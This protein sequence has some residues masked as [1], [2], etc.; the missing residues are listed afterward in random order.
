MNLNILYYITSGLQHFRI[1]DKPFCINYPLKNKEKNYN[2]NLIK[3][4]LE[5]D[6]IDISIIDEYRYLDKN[7]N[8]FIKIKES[9]LY[10]IKSNELILQIHLGKQIN[11]DLLEIETS[12]SNMKTII[13]ELEYKININ[14]HYKNDN[15]DLYYLYASP[16]V[17]IKREDEYEEEYK[18]I[19]Y[20]PE[21]KYIYNIFENSKKEC[22]CIFECANEKKLREALI[23]QPKILHISSHGRLDENLKY[24]L[25]LEEKGV[26]QKINLDRIKEILTTFRNQIKKIDLVFASTCYSEALGKLFLEYGI[27]NVIYIQGMTPV[28]DKA[29]IKFSEIFYSELIRGNTIKNAFNKSKKLIQSDKEKETFQYRKCCCSHWHKSIMY[30]PLKKDLDIHNKYHIK[31]DCDCEEYNIHEEYCKLLKM[32]KNDKAEKYFYF[33]KNSNNTIKICCICCKPID[34]N[35]KMLPH[36]ESFKFILKQ[37][38]PKDDYA[39]FYYKNKGKMNKNKNCYIMNNKDIF[40]K[41]AIVGRRKQVK[42]I[43]DI[44]DNGNIH[45]II[46]HGSYEVG[47]QNFAEQ[48]C[49][50]L[51]ERKIINGYWKINVKESKEEVSDKIKELTNNGKNSDGK[52]IVIIKINYYLEKPISLLNEILNEKSIMNPYFYYIIL[53]V[54]QDDEIGHLIH[55]QDKY[56]ILY[57]MNLI[58]ASAKQLLYDLCDSYGY[59]IHFKNL[60]I[61]NQIEELLELTGY[62]RININEL[63]ELIGKYNNFEKLKNIIQSQEFNNSG[64]IQNE[65]RKLMENQISKIYYLLTIMVNG[66]PAS[67]IYLYE[68]DFKKIIRKEDEEK[69]IYI[70]PNNNWYTIIE[71]RYKKYMVQYIQEGLKK[72]YICKC[73]EIYAKLLFFY[74]EKTRKKVCF[75]DC[76]IHYNFNSY[77]NKGIW[78][79]F[80]NNIY[81]LYFLK[82]DKSNTYNNIL[83][84]DFILEKHADNIYYL[85]ANNI[86]IIKDLIYIDRDNNV[87]QKEYLYQILLMLPSIYAFKKYSNFKIIMSKCLHL[88]DK[89]KES[90]KYNLLDSKQRLNLFFLSMKE[91]STIDF[92]KISLLGDEG[93]A[94]AYFINGIKKKDVESFLNSINLYQKIN[95]K[96]LNIQIPYAY[97]EIG[98]IYFLEKNYEYAKYYLNEGEELSKVYNDGFIKDKINIELALVMEAKYHNKDKYEFYL[99]KV[100]NESA[101]VYLISEANNLLNKLNAKLEPDIIM[102]NSNPFTKKNNYSILRYSMWAY[103]NNQYNLLQKFAKKIKRNIRIKSIVLNEKN[104]IEAFKEKGKFLIIQSD[105]FNEE[106]EIHLETKYGEGE[107]L[108]N[109]KLQEII[110]DQLN[111]E[112]VILCFIKSEKIKKYFEGKVKYLITFN[113]INIEDIDPDLLLPYNQLSI[114][115]LIHFLINSIN[116]NINQSFENSLKTFKI[117]LENFKN[118]TIDLIDKKSDFITLNIYDI[119]NKHINQKKYEEKVKKGEIIFVYP[120]LQ[121]PVVDLHNKNYTGHIL[122]LIKLIINGEE[123]INLYAKNDMPLKEEKLNIKTIIA[124]EIM[125]FLYRHQKFNDKIFYISN[126]KKYGYT[127]KAITK[128]IIGEKKNNA[129]E[130]NIS[131]DDNEKGFIVIN[132]FEK[133]NK[134][135]GKDNKNF[136]DDIPYNYQYLIISKFPIDKATIYE[137]QINK[138]ENTGGKPKKNKK[139]K[140]KIKKISFKNKKTDKNSGDSQNTIINNSPN[141][142][143]N[144]QNNQKDNNIKIESRYDKVTDFTILD[145]LSSDSD[146]S[147]SSHSKSEDSDFDL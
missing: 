68:P 60:N 2:L 108:S 39:I 44:I 99:K 140:N 38:N 81:E 102:L 116:C 54:T 36:G 18:P 45:F 135:Q 147:D 12:F 89:L 14:K 137:I 16:I 143:K 10:P 64:N 142:K 19:N 138:D 27:N 130:K 76:N 29:A 144:S 92:D 46:I 113:D 115:F 52:Y 33:E 9:F 31:C 28:S 120:L 101:N 111:Y 34:N 104:L 123:I 66:L 103:H 145:Y 74:I 15:I 127:L 72:E 21:I 83:E 17:S 79:T 32:I 98:R 93:K 41:F 11:K 8:G 112:L 125:R 7:K 58:K 57:L 141:K 37:K 78:K 25:I 94:N 96:E 77:N 110:P 22:N 70:E 133:V 109:N 5:K 105:D 126:P 136:I 26:L 49:I 87:E 84:N 35:E 122:H 65:L 88:C 4:I 55:C 86:D 128:A 134:S 146:N 53:L 121:I 90:D 48:V 82:E 119:D 71:K 80:D 114:D 6:K 85:I 1:Y 124:F 43:Y 56:K 20:R 97:Y 51:Y 107:S 118:N 3:S 63:A 42:E 24:S 131:F 61:N 139:N 50:Y 47:K 75:P 95:N 100:V 13:K 91:K 30:C 59:S 132:N 23:K 106:G 62:S 117:G 73:L 69:L 129:K 67:M 40:Q